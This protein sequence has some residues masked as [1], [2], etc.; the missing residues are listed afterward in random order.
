MTSAIR[1]RVLDAMA[2]VVPLPE[3]GCNDCDT[4]GGCA[5][6]HACRMEVCEM[7]L[8]VIERESGMVV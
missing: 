4:N 8:A 7:M 2:E 6:Q 3:F 1:S 5:N